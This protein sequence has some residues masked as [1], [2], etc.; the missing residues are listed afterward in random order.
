MDEAEVWREAQKLLDE[1]GKAAALCAAERADALLAAGDLAGSAEW[2]R[3]M[4]A[5]TSLQMPGGD[6]MH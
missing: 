5:I 1:H 6:R 2:L 3:V 4:L